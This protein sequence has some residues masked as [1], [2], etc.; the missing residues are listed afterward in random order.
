[1]FLKNIRD[2]LSG[3]MTLDNSATELTT[4]FIIKNYMGVKIKKSMC[5]GRP[6][7]GYLTCCNSF[8]TFSFNMLK[9]H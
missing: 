7:I 9:V 2:L 6:F 4:S 3:S 8:K 1:M 5:K